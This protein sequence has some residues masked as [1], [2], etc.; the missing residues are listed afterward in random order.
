MLSLFSVVQSTQP[1]WKLL[2]SD[3]PHDAGAIVA[4]VLIGGFIAFIWV[5]NRKRPS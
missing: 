3:V 1:W 2:L 4:Y 5:G